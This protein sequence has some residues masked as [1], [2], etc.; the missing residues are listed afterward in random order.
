MT[1]SEKKVIGLVELIRIIGKEKS[2]LKRAL[3]DTGATRTCVD[4]KLAGRVGLGPVVSSVKIT[5]KKGHAGY[6]RRPV[7]R[8]II[9]MHGIKIPLEMSLEDRSS[10][11]YKILLG[12]DALHGNFIV[13]VSKTHKSNKIKDITN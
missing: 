3:V 1:A 6:D 9:E 4:M 13:D 10:M 2:V 7:V 8:G 12:R 11:F 5:N